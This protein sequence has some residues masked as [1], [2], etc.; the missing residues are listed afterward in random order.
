MPV[1]KSALR[2]GSRVFLRRPQPADAKSFIA[3]VRAS[4]RLHRNWIQAPT[5]P[6]RFARYLRRFA[7]PESR[8]TATATHVGLLACRIE[9]GVPVGVFN[10]S[11][12]VRS[13]F[14]SA[15]IG[16]YAL[17]PHAGRGYMTEGLE[18]TLEFTFRVLRLHRVEINIQPTNVR[19]IA[20]VRSA[21]LTREGFSRRYVKIAGRWRDHERWALLAEDWRARRSRRR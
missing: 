8:R 7:G 16:Y 2:A 11:E 10:L 3:A 6:A 21:G 5:T 4:S 18:L 14:H 12:I 20:L 9:D 19:S 1:P 17:A 13:A 15:Y